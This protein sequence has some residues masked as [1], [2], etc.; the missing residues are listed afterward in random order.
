MANK[1]MTGF[2]AIIVLI[3][4]FAGISAREG[5]LNKGVEK[6]QWFDYIDLKYII[7]RKEKPWKY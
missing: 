1:P 6:R 4:I 3:V 7:K 5:R 2:I